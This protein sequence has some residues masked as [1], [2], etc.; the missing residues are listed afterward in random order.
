MKGNKGII[1]D[2]EDVLQYKNIRVKVEASKLP[3]P[4]QPVSNIAIQIY[5]VSKLTSVSWKGE[6]DSRW[7]TL[8]P[9]P[10]F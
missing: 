1:E 7:R 8:F 9:L 4:G 10:I 5:I 3:E 6:C 2:A